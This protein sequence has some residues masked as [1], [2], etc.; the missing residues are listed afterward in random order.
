MTQQ[1]DDTRGVADGDGDPLL[2]RPYV[3]DEAP[4]SSA[5][6]W[7]SPPPAP[8]ADPTVPLP[9][10]GAKPVRAPRRRRVLALG[11]LAAAVV[12]AAGLVGL[13]AVLRS[14]EPGTPRAYTDVSLPPWSRATS[15]APSASGVSTTARAGADPGTTVAGDGR[16]DPTG[17]ATRRPASSASA[18]AGNVPAS[19]PTS[20]A[21]TPG[22]SSAP[23]VPSLAPADRTGTIVGPG[24]LC[25]DLNGG[26]SVDGNHVQVFGCNG[27][28]AQLWTVSTDGTLRVTGKCAQAAR[29][30]EVRIDDCEQRRSAARWQIGAGG[31][32][33]NANSNECL[34]DRSN[35]SQQGAGVRLDRCMGGAN[36]Q[37]RLP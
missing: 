19:A 17:T 13:G 8:V 18:P 4:R 35:G 15:G 33:V 14:E 5:A 27:T 2:V 6:T 37:W 36:Q 7:P 26:V 31:T 24:G 21:A 25:L 11:A 32:L 9:T 28:A 34:T 30:D 29:D 12:V 16:S 20:R 3:L 23:A 22:A 10:I 1:D